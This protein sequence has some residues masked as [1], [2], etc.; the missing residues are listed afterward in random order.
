MSNLNTGF[1]R[2]KP[3]DAEEFAEITLTVENGLVARAEFACAENETLKACAAV[4]CRQIV[5]FPAADLLQIRAAEVPMPVSVRYAWT[6]WSD[7]AN[8]CGENGLPLEPFWL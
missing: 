5:G 7:Q 1:G 6:D 3:A 4:L 2:M 8:L